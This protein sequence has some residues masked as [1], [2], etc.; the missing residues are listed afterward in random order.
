MENTSFDVMPLYIVHC[1]LYICTLY[2]VQCTMCTSGI[3][4][5]HSEAYL[6]IC[7][8]G[9]VKFIF[10]CQGWAQQPLGPENPLDFT[11]PGGAESQ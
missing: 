2:N 6:E 8:V 3:N 10:L 11:V 5:A 9:G 4:A 7:P 1:T